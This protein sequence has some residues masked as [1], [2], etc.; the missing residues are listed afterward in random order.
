MPLVGAGEKTP[1]FIYDPRTPPKAKREMYVSW[2]RGDDSRSI[3]QAMSDATPFKTTTKFF[4]VAQPGDHGIVEDRPGQTGAGGDAAIGYEA[5]TT[6]GISLDGKKGTRADPIVLKA[7][8]GHKPVLRP[9]KGSIPGKVIGRCI[10]AR[11]D[12]C[13]IV[14]DGFEIYHASGTGSNETV[15]YFAASSAPGCHHIEIWNSKIHG[16]TDGSGVLFESTSATRVTKDCWLVNCDVGENNDWRGASMQSHGIY[17][18]GI[19]CGAVNSV[20]SDHV[21]GN[22]HQTKDGAQDCMYLHVTFVKNKGQCAGSCIDTRSQRTIE[23]NC[24]LAENAKGF[25]GWNGSDSGSL[26]LGGGNSAEWN[27]VALNTQNFANS[28]GSP[29]GWNFGDSNWTGPGN[30]KVADP[31]FVD[32]ANKNY[33]LKPTS[34]ARKYGDPKYKMPFD[35]DMKPTGI[36]VVCGAYSS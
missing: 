8:P 16:S 19:R 20:V 14:I 11:N 22:G 13:Y 2:S 1:D 21:N 23:R 4:S 5:P 36:D 31:Q 15:V 18:Q 29:E 34:P 7:K 32:S 25:W 17:N 30:N 24:I 12:S 9:R 27:V 10:T 35:K 33:H 3:A 6:S 28:S 26:P